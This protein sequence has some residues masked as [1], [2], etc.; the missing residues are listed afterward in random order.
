M[1]EKYSYVYEDIE[2][3]LFFLPDRVGDMTLCFV[4]RRLNEKYYFQTKHYFSLELLNN[5]PDIEIFEIAIK[6]NI[7]CYHNRYGINGFKNI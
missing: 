4:K 6:Y 3:S 2:Y 5:I 7:K 1:R